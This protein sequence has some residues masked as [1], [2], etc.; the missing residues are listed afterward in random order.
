MEKVMLSEIMTELDAYDQYKIHFA[1]YD[2][3]N[4]PLDV[5]M[6]SFDEWTDWNR[7]SNGKNE[8]NRKYIFS[9]INFY[10]ETDT[11]LFGGIWE[12]LKI[13]YK[14]DKVSSYDIELCEIWR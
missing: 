7:W 10:P 2:K 1:K 11:W 3:E 13:N 12:V 8:F 6:R 4:E 5:Y 9:L 14:G